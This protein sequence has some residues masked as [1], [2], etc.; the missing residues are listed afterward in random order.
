MLLG[1]C[2][3]LSMRC[4]R[5]DVGGLAVGGVV[6]AA[7]AMGSRR[8][9]G[10][11]ETRVF[12]AINSLP[13]EAFRA[14]WIPMQYGTIG[15]GPVLGVVA[16]TR[17]RPKLGLALAGSGSA[18]W[19]LTKEVKRIVG[20]GRPGSVLA[21]VTLRGDESLDLGFPSGHAAVSAA[22]TIVVWPHLPARWRLPPAALFVLV[23]IS[24][25]Y[26]GAH[27]PLDAIG[28]S[29]L[30]LAVGS[31]INLAIGAPPTPKT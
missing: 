21:G 1:I 3:L 27:L 17:R 12:R 18:A 28:G 13:E 6:L 29:A 7:A 5:Q 25:L 23:P 22:L 9:V 20:R 11:V 16:L 4:R 26:V 19:F 15:S 30:G 8:G 10:D 14:I 2:R 31:M 24:R